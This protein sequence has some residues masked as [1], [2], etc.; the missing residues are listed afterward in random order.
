MGGIQ[1]GPFV[2]E[3]WFF[4]KR[5][6]SEIYVLISKFSAIIQLKI[7]KIQSKKALV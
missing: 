6:H 5:R 1:F 7:K 4:L 3:N 2:Y